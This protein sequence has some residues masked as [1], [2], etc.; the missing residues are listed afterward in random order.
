MKTYRAAILLHIVTEC[1]PGASAAHCGGRPRDY[2]WVQCHCR[3]AGLGRTQER[4]V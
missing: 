2:F 3:T 1:A 4:A